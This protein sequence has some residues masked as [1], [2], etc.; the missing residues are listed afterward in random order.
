MRRLGALALTLQI[1]L[2][3]TQLNS[4]RVV[5]HGKQEGL[6]A[7][8]LRGA[9]RIHPGHDDIFRKVI[10]ERRR[11]KDDKDLYQWLKLFA[12]SIYGCFIALSSSILKPFPGEKQ[13]AM[14]QPVARL[15][16][17]P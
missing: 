10:E 14:H 17:N 11:H 6:K 12:N 5:P 8:R 2:I 3:T 13:R 16:G 4:C 1:Q 9:V 7:V 15:L